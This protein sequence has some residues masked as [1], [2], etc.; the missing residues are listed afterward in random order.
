MT[1]FGLDSPDSILIISVNSLS[2]Q[3]FTRSSY[4]NGS[5]KQFILYIASLPLQSIYITGSPLKWLQKFWG[6]PCAGFDY[7]GWGAYH[8]KY[9]NC[10]MLD[11]RGVEL[12][13]QKIHGKGANYTVLFI[14]KINDNNTLPMSQRERYFQTQ[15]PFF[16]DFQ[17]RHQFWHEPFE[18]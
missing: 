10:Y 3:P 13:F 8:L 17:L 14:L 4:K 16:F 18:K 1:S 12:F 9:P 5:Y 7:D 11:W 6:T 15:V 2:V